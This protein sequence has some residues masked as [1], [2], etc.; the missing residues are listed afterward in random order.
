MRTAALPSGPY[1]Y[2]ASIRPS[3]WKERSLKFACLAYFSEVGEV[4]SHGIE[5][6]FDRSNW[7]IREWVKLIIY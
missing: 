1:V 5:G 7:P 4:S 3:V 2:P 6:R